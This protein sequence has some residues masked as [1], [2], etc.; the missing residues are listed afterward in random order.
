MM[1]STGRKCES[2]MLVQT[3]EQTEWCVLDE[4]GGTMAR[5]VRSLAKRMARSL[6]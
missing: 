3:G 1:D 2:E 5:T 6:L 4:D